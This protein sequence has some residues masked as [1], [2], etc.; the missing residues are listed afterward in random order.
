MDRQ[1]IARE[2]RAIAREL[3]G[4]E[5]PSKDALEKYLKEHPDADRRLH[6][7][8]QSEEKPAKPEEK[9]TEKKPAE[10]PEGKPTEK[11]ADEHPK[12]KKLKESP[13]P[14]IK[15]PEE[16]KIYTEKVSQYQVEIVGDNEENAKK[17]AAELA[18][19][20]KE[21][22]DICKVNPPI[23]EGNLGITRGNMPQL[24][25]KSLKDMKADADKDEAEAANLTKKAE[26]ATDE[27]EK[28][29]L[30]SKAQ[31]AK[32]S[33]EDTKKKIQ[34]A[35]DAGADPNDDKS[36]T[37]KLLDHLEKS[38]TKIKGRKGD[39]VKVPVGELR[40]TQ[41]EIQAKKTVN[42]ADSY[43]AGRRG[44][45]PNKNP[46][47]VSTE[48]NGSHCILDGHHRWSSALM[49]DPGM[50]MNC[51]VV[52]KPIRDVLKTALDMPGVYRADLKGNIVPKDSPLD[53]AGWKKGEEKKVTEA[54]SV[55]V[56]IR[57]LAECLG[58]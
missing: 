12:I 39:T 30:T 9:P 18:K 55:G 41:R 52:D 29:E 43:F 57:R 14:D 17:V 25:D 33:A 26:A 4:F 38:G 8:K 23:C 6:T 31:K 19:G 42:M 22:A 16:K 10:K 20:I 11:P 53:L 21:T 48:E 15:S 45:K 13:P 32:D 36:T 49:A 2:L 44:F 37:D 47:I 27:K 35:I 7:V 54:R 24:H 40:A 28:K 5:F 56:E 51:I 1:L 58:L 50:E 46:I 34:A 3:V